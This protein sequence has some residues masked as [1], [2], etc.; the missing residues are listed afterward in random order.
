MTLD[1]RT[2][3]LSAVAVCAL[4]PIAGAAAKRPFIKVYKDPGCG[5]C[6]AWVDRLKEAGFDAT[7]EERAD[8]ADIK[9][10]LAVPGD[11]TSCH[12]GVILGYAVEGHVPPADVKRLIK[13]KPKAA[14]L[15][16]PGMPVNSPGMEA[17]GEANERYTVW[18]F[19]KSGER[20][21]YASHGG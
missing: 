21:P 5:C 2:V 19:Q 20:L 11:L 1:R 17:P 18:L 4:A 10:L 8:L 9:K 7:V 12:T 6:T 16:V 15:A 13:E 14:G 3:L